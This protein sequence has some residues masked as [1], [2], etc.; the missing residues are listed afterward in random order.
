MIPG[1]TLLDRKFKTFF[2]SPNEFQSLFVNAPNRYCGCGISDEPFEG[3]PTVNRKNVSLFQLI[4]RRETVNHLFI[5]RGTDGIRETVITLERRKSTRIA[6]H[7][8]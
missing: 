4:A 3:H 2:S 1:A 8:F 5:H 7:L 6:D